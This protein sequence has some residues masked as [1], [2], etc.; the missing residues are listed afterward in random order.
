MVTAMVKPGTDG[1]MAGRDGDGNPIRG[2][3]R[4]KSVARRLMEE[5]AKKASGKK[6][7]KRK[8]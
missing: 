5:Q 8:R 2:V 7:R 3:F 4:G 6:S 1:R